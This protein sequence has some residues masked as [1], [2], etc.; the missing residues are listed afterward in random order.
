MRT[1]YAFPLA[2]LLLR[3]YDTLSTEDVDAETALWDAMFDSNW[4]RKVAGIPS[5]FD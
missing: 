3:H 2:N 4:D 1:I 5:I